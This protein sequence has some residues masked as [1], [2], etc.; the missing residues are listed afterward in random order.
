[1]T[2]ASS[3]VGIGGE[4]SEQYTAF[5][6]LLQGRDADAA[7]RALLSRAHVAGQLYAL[8]GLYLID[9]EYFEA[10]VPEYEA[11]RDS[12]WTIMGDVVDRVPVA[13]IVN[14]PRGIR[15]AEGQTL[16]EWY[17]EHHGEGWQRIEPSEVYEY[18]IVGGAWPHD[19]AAPER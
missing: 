19:L 13:S 7:F 8:C 9:R 14:S 4:P 6:T 18:D 17:E 3:Y 5:N 10:V 1:R 2:F 16:A 11:S 15:L 12:V